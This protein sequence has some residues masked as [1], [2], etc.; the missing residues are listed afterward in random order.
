RHT[1]SSRDWSSDV[2]SSDLYVSRVAS[3][4]EGSTYSTW[5]S[6]GSVSNAAGLALTRLPDDSL[7]LFAVATD[8]STIVLRAS[9]DDG[10][11]WS[12]Q[13]GRASCRE[14]GDISDGQV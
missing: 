8:D 3:P 7:W 1:S 9:S 2:C 4:A 10:I 12:S 11:S 13:I 14:R 5:S 6:L